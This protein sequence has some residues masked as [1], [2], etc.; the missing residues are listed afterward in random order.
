MVA[1]RL[2]LDHHRLARRIQP[3]QQHRRLHLR[4]GDRQSIAHRHRI[5]PRPPPSSATARPCARR[6]APRTAP[7]GRSPAP[8]AAC[9]RLA[10]PVKVAVIGVVAI[11]PMIS[12]TPVP[13]LPQSITS[14]GSWNPPT[15]TP[16][17]V[18]A[19]LAMPRDRPR[20][21]PASPW[22]CP[23]RPALPEARSSGSRPP[24]SP[25]RSASGA[26]S[27]CR[28]APQP[29]R[30]RPGLAGIIGCASPWPDM[31]LSLQ[32]R[33]LIAQPPAGS[34]PAGLHCDEKLGRFS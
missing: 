16:A 7:E 9:A 11:V 18:Q 24:P 20:Q 12:R 31:A 34:M 25:R 8:S 4:R 1:R 32:N 14:A 17:T 13:E 33:S 28:P 10:S 5:W 26:R 21:R 19:S 6:P 23:A 15:P 22:P 2:L 3:R 27:T 30:Q 29:A